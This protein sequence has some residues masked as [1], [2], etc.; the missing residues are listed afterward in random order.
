MPARTTLYKPET[1][2]GADTVARYVPVKVPAGHV[3]HYLGL[4][5][6]KTMPEPD[7]PAPA[8]ARKARK[9]R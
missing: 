8:P 4:G 2:R 9:G 7:A 1:P 3:D 6:L 5:W